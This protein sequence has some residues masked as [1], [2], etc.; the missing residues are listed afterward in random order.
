[1][2][3][4]AKYHKQM[5]VVLLNGGGAVF[6]RYYIESKARICVVLINNQLCFAICVDH[7]VPGHEYHHRERDNSFD[8]H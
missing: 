1:M 3:F 6:L 8:K 4:L 5:F 2:L 7:K